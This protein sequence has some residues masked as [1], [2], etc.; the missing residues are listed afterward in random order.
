MKPPPSLP[1]AKG[2]ILFLTLKI[3]WKSRASE[4]IYYLPFERK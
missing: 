1:I 3:L 2:F 4:W